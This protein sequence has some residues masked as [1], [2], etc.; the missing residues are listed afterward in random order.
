VAAV[1]VVVLLDTK[2]LV[3]TQNLSRQVEL[4]EEEEEPEN[5]K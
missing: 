3:M 4:K 2:P 5:I 1:A